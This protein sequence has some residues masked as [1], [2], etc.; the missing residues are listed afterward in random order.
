MGKKQGS[1]KADAMRQMREKAMEPGEDATE[2]KKDKA[3]RLA[4]EKKQK[5]K[6]AKEAKK[7]EEK[8][9]RLKAKAEKAEQRK[10]KAEQRKAER[11]AK[12]KPKTG[13]L[14]VAQFSAA[15]PEG[16]AVMPS[17]AELT[18]EQKIKLADDG[19]KEIR[20]LEGRF[21]Q[22]AIIIRQF[23]VY[24][25]WRLALNPSTG[26]RGFK[27]LEKWAENA[28]PLS[29]SERFKAIK[30]ADSL[31]PHIPEEDLKKMP[32]RNLQ[33]LVSVPKAKLSDPEIIEAAKGPEKKLRKTLSKK[34]PEAGVE[35]AE[36][37]M[38]PKSIR[39][40]VDEAIEAIMALHELGDKYEALEGLAV[41]FMQG[42]T[43]NPNFSG[44]SNRDAYNAWQEQQG[45]PGDP[46]EVHSNG[47]EVA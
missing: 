17:L 24:E 6:D 2:S 10:A 37:L 14:T 23:K 39:G 15:L 21:I 45:E 5:Q 20:K 46:E 9:N 16:V 11:E 47:E 30:V 22:A 12:R 1:S 27:S 40:V 26:K 29:R 13:A 32:S 35:E 25:L 18:E 3:K 38:V 33:L 44:M 42:Q 4:A 28:M 8:A 41:Y 43:D 34:A 36:H 19:D 31:I 7:A